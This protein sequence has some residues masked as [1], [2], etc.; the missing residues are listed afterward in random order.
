MTVRI[1][2]LAATIIG[3][4]MVTVAAGQAG[5]V[6]R[7]EPA[8]EG[9]G[10][11][12]VTI[13]YPGRLNNDA[14]QPV[15]DGAYDFTFTLY[16]AFEGGS[17]VWSETQ[18]GVAV[19]SGAFLTVLGSV[20]P[21]PAEVTAS[22]KLWLEIG[23]RRAG[24]KDF[25]VL[26]PRQELA[27]ASAAVLSPSAAPTCPH[28]HFGEF[29]SGSQTSYGFEVNNQAASGDGIRG[30]SH[31][32]SA[33]DGG[34]Y[35]YNYTTGSGVYG[36]SH[37]GYGVYGY[38]TNAYAGVYGTG[39]QAGV[40]GR[41]AS[42]AAAGVHGKNTAA[43]AGG[44][45]VYGDAVGGTGVW[46]ISTNGIG[47]RGESTNS[48][49]V[50]GESANSDG[51]VGRSLRA[52]MSGVYGVNNNNTT[53]GAGVTGRS[54]KG[55]GVAG[56]VSTPSVSVAGVWGED[57]TPSG[58]DSWAVYAKGDLRVTR[59]LYV[60]GDLYVTGAK[61]GYVVD[62]A[63]SDESTP[64]EA[65]DLVAISGAAAPAVGEIPVITVRRATADTASAVLGV[66]DKHYIPAKVGEGPQAA[67][68][69]ME[70]EQAAIPSGDYLTVVT[71]GSFKAI[72]VDASFGP[73]KP[74]DL[75]VAS[76]HAG[77]AMR[78]TAPEPGTVVG[79]ALGALAEGTG[80]IPVLVTLQ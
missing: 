20:T 31:S 10:T 27:A 8:R 72:K 38:A 79:K 12:G 18:A 42:T 6:V 58:H 9:P 44:Y 52:G 28:D 73:V 50:R 76:P 55:S 56:F 30:Y 74:G 29:W 53:G 59:N 36:V 45:G 39:K 40:Y 47:V 80:S 66:V 75:L 21:L 22:S 71:L 4:L 3:V 54:T 63:R 5:G 78:A 16:D 70:T 17:S 64:L 33:T 37:D 62:V 13:P 26:S 67:E 68:A 23:V 34:L 57:I 15:S 25:T 19:K 2:L 1:R 32:T 69:K 7:A 61:H 60:V 43:N 49:G 48:N 65:G 14:G 41:T 51:V 35:G 11:A 77:Y 46:G 24:E